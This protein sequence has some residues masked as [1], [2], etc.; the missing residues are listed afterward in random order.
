MELGGCL[1]QVRRLRFPGASHS[2][3][4][5]LQGQEAATSIRL[6]HSQQRNLLGS[7]FVCWAKVSLMAA[8]PVRAYLARAAPS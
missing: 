5:S 3:W 1:T 4:T 6:S 2:A 8:Q 7:S